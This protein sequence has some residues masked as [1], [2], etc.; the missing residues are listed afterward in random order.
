MTD[1]SKLAGSQSPVAQSNS[2]DA[3]ADFGGAQTDGMAEHIRVKRPEAESAAAN[4]P[5]QISY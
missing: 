2:L 3:I 1:I 5:S 4:A